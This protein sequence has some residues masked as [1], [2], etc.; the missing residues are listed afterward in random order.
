MSCWAT[1]EPRGSKWKASHLSYDKQM[2]DIRLNQED[3]FRPVPEGSK[4]LQAGNFPAVCKSTLSF[5]DL[6]SQPAADY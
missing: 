1:P 2:N 6:A 3:M 5:E 4:L